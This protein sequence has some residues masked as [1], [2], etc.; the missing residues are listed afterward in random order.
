MM[1]VVV[2]SQ[3]RQCGGVYLCVFVRLCAGVF[4]CMPA[5]VCALVLGVSRGVWAGLE[6]D[7]YV[8]MQG[9]DI[10]M[11]PVPLRGRGGASWAV[12]F[13]RALGQTTSLWMQ[14]EG[15]L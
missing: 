10:F 5:Y 15:W 14:G 9:V 8:G 12:S 3:G 2:W 4:V 13:K 6:G 11:R 7:L 1:A